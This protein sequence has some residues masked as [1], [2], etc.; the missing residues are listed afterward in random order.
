[1]KKTAPNQ[2]PRNFAPGWS[3]LQEEQ[4]CTRTLRKRTRR[5]QTDLVFQKVIHGALAAC[6]S[7]NLINM[8][9]SLNGAAKMKSSCFLIRWSGG[10]ATTINFQPCGNSLKFI[11]PSQP[12]LQ[13]LS[14]RSVL[15]GIL[16][17]SN[18]V[19][20]LPLMFLTCTLCMR[21]SGC[22]MMRRRQKLK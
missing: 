19:D 11:W 15:L 22:C 18:G 9:R 21:T 17:L 2:R 7:F 5:W 8:R 3:D 14:E 20:S 16:S 10:G 6:T 1:M 12:A 4:N 13:L